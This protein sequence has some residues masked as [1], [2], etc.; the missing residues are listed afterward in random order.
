LEKKIYYILVLISLVV[1]FSIIFQKLE[2]SPDDTFIYMQYAR[3]I[4]SGNEFS[5]NA[6][7]PSYGVTS[8]LWVLMLI[9]P[10]LAGIDGLWFAKFLDLLFAL[11]SIRLFFQLSGFLFKKSESL[12]YIAVSMFILNPWFT[13]WAFTGMETSFAVF[14]VLWVFSL[15]YSRN[16]S[17]MFFVL[18]LMFLVRPESAALAVILFLV[19]IFRQVKEHNFKFSGIFYA[20][21]FLLPV[22]PFLIYANSQFGTIMP[23]TVLGKSGTALNA[24]V[25]YYQL[26]EIFLTLAGAS[27]IEMVLSLVFIIMAVKKKDFQNTIPLILWIA[28]LIAL[29]TVTDTDIISRYLLIISPFFIILALKTVEM[30]DKKQLQA[31]LAVFFVSL[32]FSQFIFYK[33]VKPGTDD[34]TKSVNECFIPTGKWLSENTPP[35]SRVLVND[36]GAI[37]YYSDRYIID[38]AAL[39]NSDLTLNRQ[40]MET[41]LEDRMFTHRLL[42][43][44]R[45]DYLI[46]RDTDEQN[47]LSSF[48][49]LKL[50]LMLTKKAQSLGISDSS[51]RYYKVYKIDKGN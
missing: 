39:I 13:R 44:I 43:F 28:G 34:F 37:G 47:N 29:Y 41:P 26:R 50:E 16:Y 9:V 45:A 5:F 24:A 14:L 6:G 3:N 27:I 32:F 11:W 22:V 30:L 18:G 46:E 40:I 10:Y 38:A 35:G 1:F 51:P 20:F 7:E 36:V 2:Y 33:F 17:L 49:N 15:F 25:I 4:A 8:P 31:S 42:K 21:L 23:N 19:V 12:R 48:G